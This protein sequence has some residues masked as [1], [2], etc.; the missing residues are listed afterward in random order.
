MKERLDFI[1]NSSSAMYIV[2]NTTDKTKTLLDLMDEAMDGDWMLIGWEYPDY[3][4]WDGM[5][6]L[7]PP[8]DPKELQ[9][10]REAVAR[11]QT[12]PPHSTQQVNIAWGD[13][14]PIFSV[15]GLSSHTKSFRI[16]DVT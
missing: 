3:D 16:V 7:K 8:T 9:K 15:S 2:T 10:F 11:E 5:T 13:G 6:P 4:Q 1:T 12:F 14:G